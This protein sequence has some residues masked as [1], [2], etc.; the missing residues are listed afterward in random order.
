VSFHLKRKESIAKGVRRLGSELNQEAL[1]C[2][3]DCRQTEAIHCVRKNIKKEW[4]VLRLARARIRKKDYRRLSKLLRDAA[5]HLAPV[6]DAHVRS[7]ALKNLARHFKGQLA[8]R[9]LRHM[10]MTLHAA[11]REEK[12]R[13]VERKIARAVERLLR[14]ATRHFGE[15]SVGGKGWQALCPGVEGAYREGRK[16]YHAVLKQPAPENFHE[17]RKRVKDLWYH[18]RLLQAVWPEQMD[19]VTNELGILGEHLGDDHDLFLLQQAAEKQC[20]QDGHVQ[21]FETL[22]GLIEERQREL[23]SMALR[24]GARFYAEKP[25]TFS[26]RL[27]RY[28][29][30]WRCEGKVVRPASLPDLA[31]QTRP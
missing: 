25:S 9:A 10:R 7:A 5:N 1:E 4:A 24:L 12:T 3:E 11:L 2:L 27:G 6:R 22:R 20:A 29:R 8:P 23:R 30:L 26:S 31:A 28:W 14:Q 16:A 21:E 19:A 17:W 18:V 13:F 15:L